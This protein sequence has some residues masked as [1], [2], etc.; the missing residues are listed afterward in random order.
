ME[1]MHD[2]LN[3]RKPPLQ[4]DTQH[5]VFR[6]DSLVAWHFITLQM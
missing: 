1:C 6:A 2:T 4:V 5:L 3:T